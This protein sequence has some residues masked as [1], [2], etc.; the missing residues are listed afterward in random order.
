MLSL[1]MLLWLVKWLRDP[2]KKWN[3]LFCVLSLCACRLRASLDDAEG[4]S[5][6]PGKA[7]EGLLWWQL[8][9]NASCRF[10]LI[11]SQDRNKCGGHQVLPAPSSI[12]TSVRSSSS[13]LTVAGWFLL[14]E[15]EL[16]FLS[17]SPL[18]LWNCRE[19]LCKAEQVALIL[20]KFKPKY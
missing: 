11:I 19:A 6:E 1:Q 18:S 3:L 4:G 9:S 2:E 5:N 14:C 12:F 13:L 17:P 20:K 10:S 15:L 16:R 8:L 7:W